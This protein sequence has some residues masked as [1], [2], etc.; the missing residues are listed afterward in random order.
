MEMRRHA[1]GLALAAFGVAA[2]QS[3]PPVVN[4][5]AQPCECACSYRAVAPQIGKGCWVQNDVLVCPLVKR[6]LDIEPAYPE[7]DPRCE[8]QEDG[9]LRCEVEQ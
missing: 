5:P 3:K 7:S 1:L 2:C 4:V 8:K 9:S 6:T